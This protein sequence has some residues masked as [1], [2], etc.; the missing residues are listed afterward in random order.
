MS[1]WH[2][3][4]SVAALFGALD[5]WQYGMTQ[6]SWRM[7]YHNAKRCDEHQSDDDDGPRHAMIKSELA[8]VVLTPWLSHE[9]APPHAVHVLITVSRHD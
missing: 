1:G 5:L 9:I 6:G 7:A 4:T 3:N 2:W 8:R